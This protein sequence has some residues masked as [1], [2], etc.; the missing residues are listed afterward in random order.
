[1][2]SCDFMAWRSMAAPP[3][4][5]A[6]IRGV[7]SAPLSGVTMAGSVPI[8]VYLE[9]QLSSTQG[10]KAVDLLSAGTSLDFK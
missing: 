9:G 8:A 3:C 2:G 10:K 6:G 1:M 5:V 7:I 4:Q